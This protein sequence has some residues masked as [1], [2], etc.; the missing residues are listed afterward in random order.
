M[1]EDE[2]TFAPAT[3]L[4]RLIREKKASP[5]ELVEHFGSRIEKLNS[6]IGAYVLETREIALEQAKAAEKTLVSGADVTPLHGVP[7][8]LKDLV[9]TAGIRTTFGS[10]AFANHVPPV[11]AEVYARLKRA[12][13]VMLGKTNT[14]EFGNRPTGENELFPVTRNPWDV[15]RTSGGSSAGAAAGLAAGLCAISQG[16]DG[17]GSVRIPSSC[18]GVVGLKPAR[19]RV[20]LGPYSR[21]RWAGLDTEGPIGR[22][23]LDAATLLDVMAGPGTGDPYWAAPPPRT[24]A[25]ATLERR[26]LRIGWCSEVPHAKT[27]P[28]IAAAVAG[29]AQLLSRL[30]HSVKAVSPPLAGFEVPMQMIVLAD[31]AAKPIR[32]PS[33]LEP[34]VRL[35]YEMGEK[36]LARDYLHALEE[37]NGLV[38]RMV[39]FFDDLD[40]LLT[41]TLTQLPPKIGEF[42]SSPE[43]SAEEFLAWLPFTYPFNQTGQP[44]MS[45]PL[46][47]SKSGLPIGI[48]LVGRPADERT[49]ISLGAELEEACPFRHRRPPVA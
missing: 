14:S 34:V 49:L 9:Q 4:A 13:M 24:F 45:L 31:T 5:T 19:G 35:T 23:V 41:P 16:G 32:D 20:S 8:S 36:V 38:R 7:Y 43:A 42:P 12:G 10:R 37:M 22:T 25:S 33:L 28:E 44:A 18:C 47:G 15:T 17:G 2:L 6:K 46:A 21:E 29:V 39:A 3:E 27:D 11:D 26:R 48:Q 30:G 40:V 1:A